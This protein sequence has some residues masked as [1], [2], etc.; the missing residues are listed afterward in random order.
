MK[1]APRAAV[2]R[3][4]YQ[5]VAT[6]LLLS[7]LAA[8]ICVGA[9]SR[10]EAQSYTF[11]T[12]AGLAGQ[13]GASDGTNSAA[14]FNF[15]AGIAVDSSGN[16]YTAEILNHTIRKITPVGT[17][18]VV[19]T[20]AGLAGVPGSADG[21]NSDARFDHPNGVTVDRAGN[22]FVVDHYNHTIRKIA[23]LGT[24]WAVSTVAGLAGYHNH[25]DGTNSTARFYSPTA[26]TVD[27]AGY[28]YVTD[29]AN[30][31]IRKIAPVGADWVVTT[32][33]GVALEY[34][35]VDGTNTAARFDYPYDI[36]WSGGKFYVSD[37]GNHAIRQIAVSGTDWIVST[38]AGFSGQFGS[39]DGTA[40]KAKFYFPNGIVAD[41]E[42]M[43]YVADQNNHTIRRITPQMPPPPNADWM[44]STIGGVALQPGSSDGTGSSALFNKPWGLTLDRAGNLYVADYANHIIRKG[45]PPWG[46]IPTLQIELAGN[47]AVLSWPGSASNYVLE[48]Q[49]ALLPGQPWSSLTNGI[50]LVSGRFALSRP[51]TSTSGFYRLRRL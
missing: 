23:L 47:Q 40:K 44:V 22:L 1:P 20:I 24:N 19:S 25:D 13:I 31:T 2:P 26:I 46:P 11:T 48:T 29:T 32:P 9:A 43:V 50:A 39:A 21:T 51:L 30:F 49:V 42:G 8:M 38:I 34:G 45:V 37:W 7:L 28:L 41:E 27:D 6:D 36:S 4:T 18:W 17:N 15:P 5:A 12:L 14:R 10:S 33:V 35:F 3:S 16:L